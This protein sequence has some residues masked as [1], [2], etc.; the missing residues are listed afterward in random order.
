M[1]V[2]GT[3]RIIVSK[4]LVTQGN[5]SIALTGDPSL[6]AEPATLRLVQ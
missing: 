6:L 4:K 3:R 1:A 5:G 2:A